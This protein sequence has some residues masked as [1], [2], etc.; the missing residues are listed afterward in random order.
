MKNNTLFIKRYGLCLFV[1]LA[2]M[3]TVGYAEQAADYQ[4]TP[5]FLSADAAPL[6]M[7]A[8]GK[9]HKLYYEAYNDASDLDEDGTLDVGYKGEDEPFTDSNSDGIYNDYEPFIDANANNTFDTGESFTDVN[10]NGTWDSGYSDSNGDGHW[11]E[12]IDYYGY[13]DSYKCYTYDP[14]LKRFIPTSAPVDANNRP[15][16]KCSG[17]AAADWS[18][19]FLNYLTTSR[20]DALRKVL[21]GGSRAVDTAGAT[22]QT[23]LRRAY[24]PQDAHSWGK[25]Y[26][27]VA[28][29]GYDISDYAPLTLP[30]PGTRHLFANTTLGDEDEQ[31]GLD[32][33]TVDEPILD[34]PL[35]RVLPHNTHR[36]WEWVAKE[37]PVA[38]R[39]GFESSGGNYN[40]YPY[41]HQE[42][43][44]LVAR[45][46]NSTHYQGDQ[47]IAQIDGSGNPFDSTSEYYLSIHS[48]N[49]EITTAGTYEFAVDGDDA[50][51]LMIDGQLVAAWYGGHGEAGLNIADI[52]AK[53]LLAN[54]NEPN[55]SGV[56]SITLSKG[57]HLIEF[58]HQERTG[59]DSYHLYWNGPDN[60]V[61]GTWEVVPA[62]AFSD[63]RQYFYDVQTPASTITDYVL[64][65]EVCKTSLLESNCKQYP[66]G[67]H[68]PVGLLQK[69]GETDRMYFGLMSG[70]YDNNISGGVLRKNI[71]SIS[72]EIA[73]NDPS[74]AN[75]TGQFTAVNGIINTI[76]TFRIYGF[77]Y[78]QNYEYNNEL[79]GSA[80]VTTRA[81]NDGEFPD[82]GNPVG[83]LMY[84][85]LRY[86]S[87]KASPTSAFD[88]TLGSG[89]ID[90]SLGLPKP[91]WIDP[92]VLEDQNRNGVIDTG[93]DLNSN[94]T[95]DGFENCSKPF[96]LV[97]SDIYPTY[98]SDQLPGSYFNNSF[99]GDLSYVD[100]SNASHGMD[101][102][103]LATTISTNEGLTATTPVDHFIGQVQSTYDNACTAKSVG[104][105]GEVRGLCPEEPT[106]LGSYYSSSVAYYGMQHDISSSGDNAQRVATYAVGLA[107]PL[108]QIKIDAGGNIVTMVP[109]AKS[110]GGSGISTNAATFQPTNTIVDFFVHT[111]TPTYGKFRINFEDV[112][113]GA[114]HDMD[115]I[116][117]YEYKVNANN[118]ITVNLTSTYAA[119]GIIQHMG[120]I[121]SGTT[122][123]GI[124]L[125]VR[126]VDTS[127]SNDPDYFLDTPPTGSP[128]SGY[129]DG[130]ELP[131]NASRTFTT[132]TSAGA[133]LLK[134]PLW[135]AAKWGGFLDVNTPTEDSVYGN[136][137]GT[138]DA[139]EDQNANGVNDFTVPPTP[140]L[141]EEWD[142]DRDGDPD[143][144]FYV[145]NALKLEEEL[146]KSF[147]AMLSRA[148]S[149][150]AASVI[151]NSRS[152]EGAVYQS[153]FYPTRESNVGEL[154]WVGELHALFVDSYGNLR[155]DSDGDKTLDLYIEVDTNSDGTL[156]DDEDKNN[157]SL[158]DTAR[159]KIIVFQ[160]DGT[161][162]KYDDTNENEQID[163]EDTLT[164]SPDISQWHNNG[165][166]DTED[167]DGNSILDQEDLNCD[168]I[169]NQPLNED[170][171][172]NGKLD[173]GED[174][175]AN[176][177][178]DFYLNEDANLNN[179]LDAGEDLNSDGLLNLPLN[180]ILLNT[181]LNGNGTLEA[182]ITEDADGDNILDHED[183]NCNG[184]LDFEDTNGD[185]QITILEPGTGPFSLEDINYLW[186]ATD[187]LNEN[188]NTATFDPLNQRSYNSTDPKRYLITFVDKNNN[189][190]A[191]SGEIVPFVSEDPVPAAKL[192]DTSTIY[193]YLSLFDTF[194]DESSFIS[195]L[196]PTALFEPYLQG[197]TKR[198]ID[199][200]RGEDQGLISMGSYTL[201]AMRN[202]KYDSGTKLWRLGDIV[203][204]TPT[205][206]S[207]PAE[208][209][210]LL[211]R[212]LTYA[213]F[214]ARYQKRRSVIYV[215]SNDGMIHAFNGGFFDSTTSGFTT[216][217][218]EPFSDANGNGTLDSGELHYD[219]DSNSAVNSTTN[220]Q[221][222]AEL[223]GYIPYNLLPHLY[224]LTEKDYP[225]VYYMDMQPK[226][227]DAKLFLDNSGNPIDDD[228]P[229]GWGTVMAVGMRFGGGQ[230]RADMDKTDGST[231]VTNTDRTM[232]SA[233]VIFD[234][235]NPE[236]APSVLGE[237]AF[238]GLGYTTCYPAVIP[239]RSK[240][241]FGSST[242]FSSNDWY[243][244]V[245][246]GPADAS[247]T[248]ATG[249]PLI[250]AVS[251]QKG[252]IFILDLKA[253]VADGEVRT[254]NDL[255][256]LTSI[257]LKTATPALNWHFGEY[258]A[259]SFISQPVTVDYDLNFNADAAYFGTIS[260]DRST[261]WGGKVRR[262]IFEETR[263]NGA[264]NNYDDYTTDYTTWH[265]I[266][267]IDVDGDGTGDVNVTKSDNVL[268]DLTSDQQ[269]ISA[270]MSIA[271]DSAKTVT[272][273]RERWI[274]FG[275][276][277]FLVRKDAPN[278]D[279][280][281]YYGLKEPS[282]A[283]GF[284]WG[285][286]N[287]ATS[288]LDV[289]LAE[290]YDDQ[291]VENVTASPA[292]VDWE[293][294]IF[295]IDTNKSGW[296]LDFPRQGERNLGS[297]ALLGE[298]LTYTTYVPSQDVCNIEG[299]SFL[300]ALYYKTGT[301]YF[302]PA[303]GWSWDDSRGTES[304]T[305]EKGERLA[306]T[307]VS[308]GGGMSISPNIH[309]GREDGSKAFVQTSTGAIRGIEQINPG[310][311]KS[312]KSAWR[313][314]R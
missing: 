175:N 86:F 62:T 26:E 30:D 72:D 203:H 65:V 16:K 174:L 92:Y 43:I 297:A 63:L 77:D 61:V 114:D 268:I 111:I 262:L 96:I 135:Y 257:G 125:E 311:S 209:Y 106:K 123:D 41:D 112:E 309:T 141:D 121:I 263:L 84:E 115:A 188:A 287:K 190:V 239:M 283:D 181:D 34:E 310:L 107:S 185:G 237:I 142:V 163:S 215:G 103:E 273:D 75:N 220:Y 305:V 179:Q 286:I 235:T 221:L 199:Y 73:I 25:E 28:T 300:Y 192:T 70:S 302:E 69:Y 274:F 130:K 232:R 170:V 304:G 113:Q 101:V 40:S 100:T 247:G 194:G 46:A 83:E 224:W 205:V 277:R 147:T 79:G 145:V 98:D 223:W 228:H 120:Y 154:T 5:P 82:W 253:L 230:I 222:G 87:G 183:I 31:P 290:V 161:V 24:I 124:Y 58:R 186:A 231:F 184:I 279:Q 108:P 178:L 260:G 189:M 45:F 217:I 66:S 241:G 265:D 165:Q 68:K 152:G 313:E 15:I 64:D 149:G 20:M 55:F 233:L 204:S 298:L 23:I 133:T 292:I 104:N 266:L 50:V 110:V 122:E 213:E 4:T 17:T 219:W 301:G 284:T 155:E 1:V 176:N 47:P 36:I 169:L 85:A 13:F 140:D 295:E 229:G 242:T 132:G 173:A 210:H 251:K 129:N 134:N 42:Y 259:N 234:I 153:I 80:W 227:F 276:G 99:V 27:S 89:T 252:K 94:G 166:L 119:G 14:L 255:G 10:S 32:A 156:D 306:T 90:D 37:R 29:D 212:D 191:D 271:L 236:K 312:G 214:L 296:Y 38:T 49:L 281:S 299:N 249:D 76:D 180:E 288:L 21:Y 128:G 74:S 206:V 285:E 201:P 137:D 59:S 52:K 8:M 269:P 303:I 148:S 116:V 278:I 117:E 160:E 168:G 172:N 244:V 208:G 272:G 207:S 9:N 151:S 3:P 95:L 105:L 197:Q 158:W 118:S 195:A 240:A 81:M 167:A 196:R 91:D 225:H 54:T 275:T 51:E 138:L 243:L 293:D 11:N 202:R 48:G 159:D 250:E 150:T 162:F 171:N 44:D 198:Q 246:S 261:G 18:G 22:G 280:Q 56:E 53:S 97:L 60:A 187:W 2:A 144:Y 291:T 93:E 136:D 200:I 164:F 245:G 267:N 39:S 216:T 282:G 226:I 139:G 258:D 254:I 294:L 182:S 67:D 102:H 157:N 143:N 307:N 270:P 218:Q 131:L 211:Y 248:P 88:Y 308:L 146:S 127:A 264:T 109:F 7:L 71:S 19:D 314:R 35:L 12:G 289:S 126:D 238:D 177:Q 193:P 78:D 6:I 33:D 256:S 57:T